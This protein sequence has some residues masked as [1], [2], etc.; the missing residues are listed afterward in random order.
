MGPGVGPEH[1]YNRP[2]VYAGRYPNGY[3]SIDSLTP[4]VY[5]VSYDVSVRRYIIDRHL[6]LWNPGQALGIPFAAQGEGSPYFLFEI[7]RSVLPYGYANY[8]TFLNFFFAAIFMFC[9]L[10]NMGI[11]ENVSYLGSY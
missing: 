1:I 9:F 8:I 2:E 4:A 6:P 10:R 11:S 5:N 7:L 3:L